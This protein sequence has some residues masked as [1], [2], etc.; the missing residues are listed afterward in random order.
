VLQNVS[1]FICNLAFWVEQS[2]LAQGS[3]WSVRCGAVRDGG[4]R[5][6]LMRCLPDKEKRC[7]N[8]KTIPEH[9]GTDSKGET[10]ARAG[11]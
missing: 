5:A 3:L 7:W 11:G 10:A 2:R 6:A 8:W 1:V 4:E 9:H